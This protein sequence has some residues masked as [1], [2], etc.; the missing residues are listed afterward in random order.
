M[1]NVP[2]LSR[3]GAGMSYSIRVLNAGAS[4]EVGVLK[5]IVNAEVYE[6]INDQ[7]TADVEIAENKFPSFLQYPNLLEIEGDYFLIAGIDKQRNNSKSIRLNLEH[8]S[9]LLNDPFVAPFTVE[10]EEEIYEGS[11]GDILSRV[12]GLGAFRI[13]DLVGGYY[14]YRP[15]AKGGR[16]R[17]NEFARQNGLEVEYD[18]FSVIIH[19]RRGGDNGLVLEVGKNIE[20]IQQKIDLNDNFSLEYAHE[21]EIID[22]AKMTGAQKQ[23]IASAELGDTVTMIDTDLAIHATERIVGRRYNP[24]FKETPQLDVGQII[25]DFVTYEDKKEEEEKEEEGRTNYY[26]EKFQIGDIDCL[27]LNGVELNDDEALPEGISADIDF[28]LFGKLKGVSLQLKPNYSDY[29]I[30]V[31]KVYDDGGFETLDY[32]TNQS[33]INSWSLPAEGI[34]GIGVL[35]TSEPF[36]AFDANEDDFKQYGVGFNRIAIDVLREFK[37]GKINALGLSGIDVFPEDGLPDEIDAEIAYEELN[38]H[39]GMVLSLKKAYRDWYVKLTTYDSKGA[40][41]DYNFA[42]IK[43]VAATW[44]LPNKDIEA[45]VVTVME[46]PPGQFN[47][48]QHQQALYGVKF[49]Q[50]DED[51]DEEPIGDAG[52]YLSEFRI[53]DVDMLPIASDETGQALSFI[54][55]DTED[56]FA[57]ATY[58]T[59]EPL[60]GIFARLQDDYTEYHLTLIVTGEEEDGSTSTSSFSWEEAQQIGTSNFQFPLPGFLKTS[61]TLVI[62]DISPDEFDSSTDDA[63]LKAFGVTIALGEEDEENKEE[64]RMEFGICELASVMTYDFEKT[65]GYDEVKSI[66]TG[67]MGDASYT[68]N[69]TLVVN[70]IEMDGKYTS[71]EIHAKWDGEIPANAKV[72]IQAICYN[73]GGETDGEW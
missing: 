71:V 20:S 26:L 29:H 64:Y 52:E 17:I 55:G 31:Y 36:N 4:S 8:V 15:S 40:S 3:Y 49:T 68:G 10:G 38:E 50:E 5:N 62:T 73:S 44:M 67:L 11:P 60:T 25:R 2:V 66:T 21:V 56:L 53:G 63:F 37:V 70:P 18:K 30:T 22:F 46:Q 42:D 32:A 6:V 24:L 57:S 7:Y 65:E 27:N 48:S 23:D 28:T 54:N 72:S 43:D 12:W 13:V 59:E 41:T 35:V 51:E 47:A 9:Y 1:G 14:E 19:A 39:R 16:S 45:I 34:A 58:Q 61:I 33:T 69:V